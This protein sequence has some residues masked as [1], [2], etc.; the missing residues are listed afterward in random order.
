[1]TYCCQ[2]PKSVLLNNYQT[3]LSVIFLIPLSPVRFI[4]YSTWH[5]FKAWNFI[6]RP[7]SLISLLS[8]ALCSPLS[9]EN[10]SWI[11]D[12]L[13]GRWIEILS[14]WWHS[15]MF[16]FSAHD[17]DF[18]PLFLKVKIYCVSFF[19]FIFALE[20]L[21]EINLSGSTGFI[22]LCVYC[23]NGIFFWLFCSYLFMPWYGNVSVCM[24]LCL[25]VQLAHLSC[26]DVL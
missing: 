15:L 22:R 12:W 17:G 21:V 19:P 18:F 24:S 7:P 14:E 4:L 25:S 11:V 5:F 6:A 2:Y 13:T 9:I 16:F 20:P 1:M 3:D 8:C 26:G 10:E 23:T